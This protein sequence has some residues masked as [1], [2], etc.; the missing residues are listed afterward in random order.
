MLRAVKF[1]LWLG[2]HARETLN[3][4]ALVT[5]KGRGQGPLKEEDE[6]KNEGSDDQEMYTPPTDPP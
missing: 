5:A 6:G 1:C 2:V 3:V 4:H